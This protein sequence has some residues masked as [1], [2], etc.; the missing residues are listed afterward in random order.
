MGTA[1][2][3]KAGIILD[4]PVPWFGAPLM[5]GGSFNL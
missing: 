2:P 5:A 4:D 3:N 1:E